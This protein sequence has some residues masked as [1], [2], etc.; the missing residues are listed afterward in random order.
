[1][2]IKTLLFNY[3]IMKFITFFTSFWQSLRN[4]LPSYCVAWI[5]AIIS[6]MIIHSDGNM[7]VQQEVLLSLWILFPLL[8]SL[9]LF[10]NI[11][12]LE[13]WKELIISILAIFL[14]VWFWYI[15]HDHD[16]FS[17]YYNQTY[18][19]FI[20]LSY[21]IAR[22]MLFATPVISTNNS[23]K[24]VRWWR[25]EWILNMLVA[26]IGWL[27]LRWWISASIWSIEY[28]F[29]LNISYKRYLS[30]WVISL[31][32][33]A[34]TIFF[35]KM[36]K[37]VWELDNYP[38]LLR[39]FWLY[40]FLPLAW[41]YAIILLSYGLKIVFTWQWPKGLVSMMVIWYVIRWIITYRAI[42]PLLADKPY[43]LFSRGFW[44]SSIIFL[45]LLF[46]A[47]GMR[48]AQYGITEPRYF[49]VMIWLW[50]AIVA[51]ISLIQPKKSFSMMIF[52]LIG[53]AI[54]SAYTPRSASTM[55]FNSQENQMLQILERYN[56][57]D[58]N[59]L[60]I[61]E[62][63]VDDL[64]DVEKEDLLRLVDILNYLN[65]Y[66]GS[67]SIEYLWYNN[68]DMQW[69]R[70]ENFY[71][72]FW[73]QLL[74]NIWYQWELYNYYYPEEVDPNADRTFWIHRSD[75]IRDIDISSYNSYIEINSYITSDIISYRNWKN[76]IDIM[77]P[78]NQL[79]TID[80]GQLGSQ[81]LE[82]SQNN[83]N[84]LKTDTYILLI[85]NLE[86]TKK[87]DVYTLGSYELKILL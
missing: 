66:H 22:W 34:V 36:I 68:S 23:Y 82:L 60:I 13:L 75:T 5:A 10:K 38:S 67:G 16:I 74:K 58:G 73:N 57:W 3:V 29:D 37:S 45:P 21:L 43:S 50:I 52:G 81:F 48:L 65:R 30:V 20:V 80:L 14:S 27:I 18:S 32:G 19:F 49:T 35:T 54:S 4:Y 17:N 31:L 84:I 39:F 69:L 86:V 61:E 46:G 71:R 41:L 78:D 9:S 44:I 62:R 42:T 8:T 6:I 11:R 77:L 12:W 55:S 72:D 24:L 53:L 28:L 40:I 79:F 85:D 70:D 51:I 33:F 76:I 1:M 25:K 64:N 15:I 83:T 7:S 56:L 2:I 26:W 59:Q 87:W 47:I 63:K